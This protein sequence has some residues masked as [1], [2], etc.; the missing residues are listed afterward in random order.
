MAPSEESIWTNFLLSPSPL[1]TIISL[2]KFTEL[3]PKRLQ[4]H[5][6]IRVLYRELQHIRSQDIDLVRE[7]IDKEIRRGERQKEELRIAKHATGISGM[8]KH[9]KME[10]DMDVLLFGQ[11]PDASSAENMHTL[12]SLLPEMENA[13]ASIEKEIEATDAE[14]ARIMAELTSV[15][16]ELSDLRYGRFNKPAGVATNFVGETIKGLKELESACSPSNTG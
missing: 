2:E 8:D 10:M 12:D 16:G 11:P 5:P 4:S 14:A 1:P 15:V 3:F 13:C 6:Q 9:D 7:N